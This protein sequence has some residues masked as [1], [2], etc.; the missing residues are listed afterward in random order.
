MRSAW[1]VLVVRMQLL[2]VWPSGATVEVR[3]VARQKRSPFFRGFLDHGPEVAFKFTRSGFRCA[4]GL[5]PRG[6][7]QGFVLRRRL[8]S[9]F[10]FCEEG[11]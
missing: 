9:S 4:S 7:Q 1:S 8:A 11:V 3:L 6:G 10:K 5:V 2:V